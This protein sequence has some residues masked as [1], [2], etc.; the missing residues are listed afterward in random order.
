[1]AHRLLR[2]VQADGEAVLSR[3]LRAG[4]GPGGARAGKGPPPLDPSTDLLTFL[5]PHHGGGAAKEHAGDDLGAAES[6]PRWD[7]DLRGA[8]P[9]LRAAWKVN[10]LNLDF[11]AVTAI[12]LAAMLGLCGFVAAVMP[13]RAG[14]TRQTD[15][16]EFA[17][18]TLLTVIFSPL[19]FNYAYVWL[20]YPTT[21]A[22][23]RVVSEPADAPR[24]RLKVAWLAAVLLI[25]AL[26]IPM[27]Q[28]A[29]A[30]G[31]LFVPAVLL[32]FGLGAMLRF[33]PWS[34]AG[35][36]WSLKTMTRTVHFR[37]P[38]RTADSPASSRE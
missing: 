38:A 8:E 33:E 10:V 13:P 2:D 3:R 16:L 24:H 32:V 29:Q 37:T 11:R 36:E 1:V 5:K 4:L 34:E 27:P 25:P 19:S 35:G 15:A 9:A 18:V 12:T 7:E 6:M 21:L 22:L 28:L 23:H 20:L 14:R 31:N 17:L 26:A 30:C